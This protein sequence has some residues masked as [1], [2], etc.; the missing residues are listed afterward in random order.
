MLSSAP[1]PGGHGGEV[2]SCTYT[3]DGKQVLSGG[4]DGHL[5]LWESAT[6]AQLTGFKA[7]DKPVS[8]C[9]I[10]PDNSRWLSGA[11]DGML[12]NW[13][14]TTQ[15]RLSVFLAHT[16][17]ISAI[18]FDVDGQTLATSSWDRSVALWRM[19]RERDNRQLSGHLDIVAGCQFTPDGKALLSWS[20]DSSLR[21]WETT[22]G[23]QTGQ[24]KGHEHRV[25][26]GAISPDGRFAASAARDGA[27]R[28]WELET[29]R[30]LASAG[31]SYEVRSLFFLLNGESLVSVQAN[32]RVAIHSV[33]ELK[34]QGDWNVRLPLQCGTL[35]PAGNQIALG[36][37]DGKVR[38][39]AIDGIEDSAFFITPTR[40]SQRTTTVLGR[41]F[42]RS[43]VE[44]TFAC[45]C[46]ACRKSF[47]VPEANGKQARLCPHCKRPVRLSAT[48]RVVPD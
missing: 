46:P 22:H 3:P 18:V 6:G 30:E 26:A 4:W 10:S 37:D 47:Q 19:N 20:H 32:G 33:P 1:G 14:P 5:R 23:R 34:E 9:A 35:A 24:L 36:C 7:A 13:D 40:T 38:F 45:V 25:T 16:R 8:A 21:L 28:A 17:P 41:L 44:H 31:L 27:L 12:A 11:L 29:Q 48:A 2:F 42:G 39:L 43:K 15:K